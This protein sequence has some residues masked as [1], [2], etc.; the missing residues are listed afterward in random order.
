VTSFERLTLDLKTALERC[1]GCHDQCMTATAELAASGRQDLVTSRVATL[2]LL[3]ERGKIPWTAET[4]EPVFEALGDGIQFEYCIYRDIGQDIRPYLRFLR[5]AARQRGI[6]PSVVTDAAAAFERTGNLLGL[7]EELPPVATARGAVVLVHD[8]ATRALAPDS[9]A[10]AMGALA[11]AGLE[12]TALAV[13]SAGSVEAQLGLASE[14]TAAADLAIARIS[15]S[16]PGALVSSDPVLIARLRDLQADGRL[17]E[18]LRIQHLSTALAATDVQWPARDPQKI[19]FHDP[20]ALCRDLDEV[21]SPRAVLRRVPGVELREPVNH[22]RLASN[23]G[24]LAVYPR[25]ALA[26]AIAARRIAELSW[27]GA[28]IVVTASPYSLANLRAVADGLRV[29][30]LAVFLEIG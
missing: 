8:A 24:P 10:A 3:L 21:E 25:P 11:R 7:Q 13:G 26:R 19:A 28:P 2:G 27:T 5:R 20:A 17:P 16:E 12:P 23:D 18:G 4:A 29:V 15:A 9:V 22:G 1:A 6:Q 14:A 30:D